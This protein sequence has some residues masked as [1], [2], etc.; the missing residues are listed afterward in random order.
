MNN[1]E[2]ICMQSDAFYKLLEEVIAHFK[3]PVAEIPD[4]WI[5]AS[6]AMAKLKIKSKTTLQKLRDEGQIRFTQPKKKLILY[7][8]NSI[9]EYLNDFVYESFEL[10]KAEQRKV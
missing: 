8:I 4:T 3:K 9:N 5:S 6:E 1:I 10:P 7:D 2:V